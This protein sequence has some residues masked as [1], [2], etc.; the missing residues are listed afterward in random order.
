M[1]KSLVATSLVAA[2]MTV[3]AAPPGNPIRI[4]ETAIHK[5]FV[6]DIC[7]RVASAKRLRD[8]TILARCTNREAFR[9]FRIDG[10]EPSEAVAIRCNIAEQ[11]GIK[12]CE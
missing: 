5:S 8:G 6:K 9:V 10:I 11:L 2:Q 7:P 12:G 4:A 1:L 3:Y